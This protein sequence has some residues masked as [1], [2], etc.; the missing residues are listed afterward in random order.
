MPLYYFHQN[1]NHWVIMYRET[2]VNANS[3][4]LIIKF[5]FIVE[6]YL[7]S[8][9]QN[10]VCVP[11]DLTAVKLINLNECFTACLIT[12][13]HGNSVTNASLLTKNINHMCVTYCIITWLRYLPPCNDI[14]FPL[15]RAWLNDQC[16]VSSSHKRNCYWQG[17]NVHLYK[18]V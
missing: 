1:I 8:R 16:P 11:F 14:N 17:I 15:Q 6:N 2:N 10:V 5:R 3:F 7:I 12:K 13:V 9:L 18:G 4:M